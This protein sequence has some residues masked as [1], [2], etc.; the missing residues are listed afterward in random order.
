MNVL[1]LF[2]RRPKPPQPA[3]LP[4][5]MAD[6]T[7]KFKELHRILRIVAKTR[8]RAQTR[9]TLHAKFAQFALTLLSIGLIIIPVFVLGGIHFAF[10]RTHVDVLQIAFAVALL[11]Y[12]VVLGMSRFEA[13]AEKMHACGLLVSR[14]LRQIEPYRR[15]E[16]PPTSDT[17]EVLEN[18]YYDALEKFENHI[19]LDYYS[20][21][22][23]LMVDE[24]PPS[25]EQGETPKRHRQRVRR[26]Y[27]RLSKRRAFVYLGRVVIF[28]HYFVSVAALYACIF[29]LIRGW[30]FGR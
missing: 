1:V 21:M 9:L 30:P 3:V 2:R 23:D 11:G 18:R 6:R 17:F 13:R 26:Y 24:G 16:P 29:V 15:G 12:S 27:W 4:L 25:I 8:Y 14:I 10:Q 5:P 20:V 19:E 22:M 28:G 7:E